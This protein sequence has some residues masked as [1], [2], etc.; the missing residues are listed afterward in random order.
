MNFVLKYVS[1]RFLN[2]LENDGFIQLSTAAGRD[3]R[4]VKPS[5]TREDFAFLQLT[6]GTT[7]SAKLAILTHDNLLSN[8]AQVDAWFKRVLEEGKE[9]VITALP[10]YHIFSL[11]ANCFLFVHL[12]GLNYLI[13][14]PRDMKGFVRELGKVK[15]S[16]ITGVNTLYNGLLN[17]EGF[18]ALD[19]SHLKISLGGGM[20]VQES[21]ADNWQQVTGCALASLW[22]PKPSRP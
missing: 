5:L 6:G 16:V 20:A 22:P 13:T 8:I 21:I 14:N 12:G 10:L 9:V 11:T 4:F 1:T 15:F 18:S 19:F 17:T 3:A 7:G 2:E